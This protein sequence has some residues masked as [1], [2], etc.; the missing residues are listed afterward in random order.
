[1]SKTIR[2]LL[3]EDSE[4]DAE[5]AIR[6]LRRGGFDVQHKRVQSAAALQAALAGQQWD[7]V[8]SDFS[9]PGF[10]GMDALR[11]LQ[12]AGLDIPFILISGTIGEETAVGAMKAGASDYIMK[13]NLARLAPALERELK[14][15]A[16]RAESRRAQRSLIESEA[17]LRRA[18][19]MAELAHVIT[20]P[21]GSFES[22]SETLPQLIAL[23]PA[24]MPTSTREFLE[25]V[26]PE[27]RAS[28]RAT[29]IEAGKR[30]TRMDVEYRLRRSDD[31]WIHI[32]QTFEPLEESADE[33]GRMR[34][35]NT[36]Q[37][38]SGQKQ[39]ASA[40]RRSEELYRA[41]FE[42]V[43]V[44]MVRSSLEGEFQMVNQ[45]L[46]ELTGYPRGEAM[47]L[48]IRD[49]IHPQDI[50]SSIAGRSRML[51][52][53]GTPCQE[54]LRLM[55]KGGSQ[56]WVNVTTSLVRASGGQPSYFVSIL[57]D[58]SERKHADE[59]IRRLNRV[60]AVLSGINALIVRVRDREEL[61]RE[62]CR[63]AVEAG[64]FRLAWLGVVDRTAMRVNPVAWQG[65][66]QGYIELM[67]LR[68]DDADSAGRGLVGRAVAERKAMI[69]DDMTLDPRVLLKKEALER[70]LHSLAVL[71]LVVGEE[72]VGVLAL[73]AG[74]VGFFDADEMK[75]LHELA[76]DIAFA[77]DHI[78]KEEKVRR[79]TRVHAVLTG[80][81]AAIVR[82]RDREEL[83]RE[84]CRIAVDA[85]HLRLAWIGIVDPRREEILP[86]AFSGPE[87]GLLGIIRLST[88]ENSGLFGMAGR[89]IRDR[90]PAVSNDVEADERTQFRKESVQRGFRSVAM[91]PLI[92]DG[93]AFGV[94]GLHAAEAGFFDQDEMQL[95]ME[96][97]G[98]IAFALEHIDKEEKVRRLTRTYAVLSGIN[99][100][101]VRVRDRD[102]LFRGA[103]RIAVEAGLFRMSWI[104]MV[105]RKAMKIEPVASAG[106]KPEYMAFIKETFSLAEELPMGNTLTAQAIR[107]KKAVFSNDT[108]N[109]P[110][111]QFKKEHVERGTRSIAVLP[112]LVADEAVGVLVLYTEEADFFDA[113][114]LNLLTELAGDI[115]FALDHIEKAEKLD[116]LAYY[117]SL[118]GLA[119]RSLFLE[120]LAQFLSAASDGQHKLAL[121]LL[122]IERFK[123]INDSLGRHAGDA[124]LKQMADRLQATVGEQ[125]Q[126][127]RVGADHFAIVIPKVK[128]EQDLPRIIEDNRRRIL[129]NPF[130]VHGTELRVS[131]KAGVA[132]FPRD[133]ADADTLFKNAEAALTKAKAS[134]EPHLFYTQQMTERSGE[135]LT[136]E[137]RLRQALEKEE[138]VLH[139]QSKV[140]ST[141]GAI[142]GVEALIRWNSAELGL[143]PPMKFIP[144]ME[145]TGLILEVGAW[146]LQ[147][148]VQVHSQW[149]K[150]GLV[151]PRIAVNVS[152]I[153]LR[154]RDFVSTV[155]HALKQG[156]VPPGIDLEITESLIMEDIRGNI[157]KLKQIR[158]LG[159]GIAIDDFGTGYSSLAYLAKLPVQTL[160]IDRSFIIT[161]LDDPDTMSLVSTMISLAQSLRLRVVAEGVDAEEQAKFL[162]LLRCD[163]MQGYLFSK[164]LPLEEMTALLRSA[165]LAK[166]Q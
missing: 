101:I 126:L 76:G 44:G 143:V 59:R 33:T 57:E 152:P 116:Y 19:L 51:T 108:Q 36:L 55:R 92:V 25:L 151:A 43:A 88:R 21:D 10:T 147:K 64:Q 166:I 134:G 148:A 49:I 40:L 158:D 83:F 119:N 123:T 17:G 94:L 149:L 96:V 65:A 35:F 99:A 98:N 5:L 127:A 16:M 12:S 144:L 135:K 87:E 125:S 112:L 20:G 117:D 15:A 91:I 9:M 81:N 38:V 26:H 23:T 138:F 30:G 109:D 114:E 1:V 162:R 8:I 41:T 60:Y 18:Q 160:K 102:E 84:S 47:L 113:A 155:V 122:D 71:P 103:C 128:L 142:L 129:E 146:A 115:S 120:R 46:C 13:E 107:E 133:G 161:M 93:A 48:S 2:L 104:G 132:L 80:I 110:R 159:V 69:S 6:M 72:V 145:E 106:S 53:P 153:Q 45:K 86:A 130:Q 34:W 82:I 154:K 37:D 63:I 105:D 136:M 4:D 139:Y 14:E 32:R 22:W 66:G 73:Y 75:L 150:Q 89:A 163:E 131:T 77:L 74:E 164:P 141:T 24:Q 124:L 50:E 118:T 54:E 67:P 140:D 61:F 137:N 111:V 52:G 58:I 157:E 11:I 39:A 70:G 121:V 78:E 56:T 95:L 42:Q 28:L 31:Q 156:A 68:L 165:A 100:L 79:L 62:A 27:D 7:A 90:V 29:S 3:L 97:V 85:G